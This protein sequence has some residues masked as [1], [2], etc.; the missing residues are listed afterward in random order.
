MI[1]IEISSNMKRGVDADAA[2]YVTKRAYL[3]S[4][5]YHP[6]PPSTNLFRKVTIKSP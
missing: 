1:Y 4:A 6:P 5:P 3:G 2:S